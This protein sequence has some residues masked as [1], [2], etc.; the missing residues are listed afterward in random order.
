MADPQGLL[1]AITRHRSIMIV[2]LMAIIACLGYSGVFTGWGYLTQIVL[3][4]TGASLVAGL[5][6]EYKLLVGE[7]VV[8][9]VVSFF[10]LGMIV[11]QWVPGITSP[12][13]FATGLTKGWA[14]L[15]S[16]Q[17]PTTLS[18]QRAVVPFTT[19]WV[20]T[21]IAQELDRRLRFSGAAL[22]G[23]LAGLVATS[24]FSTEARALAR[25]QGPALI[26]LTIILGLLGRSARDMTGLSIANS[27]TSTRR[28][29]L[30]PA[31]VLLVIMAIAATIG[32]RLPLADAR[33]RF[34]LRDRQENP[35]DPL[36][37]PS[38]L[39]TL[40]AD[41][42]E[43]IADQV[44]FRVTS[45][46]PITRWTV[47]IM[48]SYDGVVWQV[49]D[50]TIDTAA[51]FVPVDASLPASREPLADDATVFD[52]RVEIEAL[53]GP[54]IPHAGDPA[55]VSLAGDGDVRMNLST[56]TLALP[57]GLQ[58]GDSYDISTRIHPQ[59]GDIA[60]A[61]FGVD[62]RSTEL[63][64]VPAP[65][66][67]LAAELVEGADYG[68]PQIV[69]IRDLFTLQGFY[70]VG[71]NSP[72]GHSYA[73]LAAFIDNPE[74]IV[75]YEEHYA[76]TAAVLARLASIPT[77]VAVGYHIDED[78]YD[79]ANTAEVYANDASAWI[80]VDVQGVGWVPV[81]VTPDRSREPVEEDIGRVT[82]N[83]A[84]PNEPPPPPPP[85]QSD[86]E[87]ELEEDEEEDEEDEEETEE[88]SGS[89]FGALLDNPGA[90]AAT[91]AISPFVAIALLGLLALVLK[92]LRTR[93]RRNAE[94]ERLQ[95]V[96]AWA[97]LID[98]FEEAGHTALPNAT[99][100]E[101]VQH[102]AR[103]PDIAAAEPELQELAALVSRSAFAPTEPTT[104]Q[105]DQA[106]DKA[107]RATDVAVGSLTTLERTR[108]KIDPRPLLRRTPGPDD[109]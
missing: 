100:T 29:I 25:F 75:G 3:A 41:L 74:R 52:A 57:V 5:S 106:W 31:A 61:G 35:W 26:G 91:I 55:Q 108:M 28:R 97:E 44:M 92:R 50:P 59:A 77:R 40:K 1:R 89:L 86:T 46:S 32:P 93:R 87:D 47:A 109:E 14:D 2:A 39:V 51:Q 73:R 36:D 30:A 103:D 65:I 9:S 70:D 69:A 15:L 12:A 48:A 16:S 11:T 17:T 6:R 81:D 43:E 60:L 56:R 68:G 96:G 62:D 13:D 104:T 18:S 19:A 82:R 37:S 84:V 85:Q 99:P 78:R 94:T 27:T 95:I 54:W 22:I 79:S 67:N 53:D 33:D 107:E 80:E 45:E 66:L 42:K 102:F 8:V 21:A 58:A 38:P 71:R 88:S 24:L 49:A 20:A 101:V 64:K 105:V 98:R 76:A 23:V 7:T 72:P 83:V 63:Q 4:A 10:V 90:V 34:D